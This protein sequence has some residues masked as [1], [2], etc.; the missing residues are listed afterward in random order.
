M[1]VERLVALA[2]HLLEEQGITWH[3]ILYVGIA[4]P[5]QI[6]RCVWIGE[7][8]SN[9][10]PRSCFKSSEAPSR[11]AFYACTAGS[12]HRSRNICP[13]NLSGHEGPIR[14]R[15]PREDTPACIWEV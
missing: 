9:R 7:H 3:D 12:T 15:Q 1:V 4:C 5:G 8:H 2:Q 11:L 14:G 13:W 10:I 6:D